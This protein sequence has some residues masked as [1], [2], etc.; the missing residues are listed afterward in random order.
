MTRATSLFIRPFAV[1]AVAALLLLYVLSLTA[2][3]AR[4][5]APAPADAP[6]AA[7][8]VEVGVIDPD[9]LLSGSD[10]LLLRTET[11]RLALPPQVTHVE[12]AVFGTNKENFNDTMLDYARADRPDLVSGDSWA[13]GRLIVAV[14][15]DPHRNG[16]YCGDD[17]CVALDIFE[18]PHLDGSLEAMKDPLRRGN[19]GA[20]LLAG[21]VAAADP[22]VVASGSG[23][24][25]GGGLWVLG[26]AGLVLAGGGAFVVVRNRRKTVATAR[27]QFDLVSREYGRVAGE[28][29]G[30]DVRANSLSSVLADDDLRAQWADVRDRFLELD[31]VMGRLGD[32]RYDSTDAEFR[33]AAKDIGTA[34]G[35]VEQMDRAETNID[36]MFRMEQGDVDV[37][38]RHLGELHRDMGAAALGTS[39]QRLA[40]Q[41]R[42]LVGQVDDLARDPA[43]PDFMDRYARIVRDYRLVVD[44]IRA[45]DLSDVKAAK[46]AGNRHAPRIYD[47]DWQV[48][49]GYHG[50]VPYYVA[51]TWHAQ[52]VA[53][54]SSSTDTGYSDSSFSGGGGSSSW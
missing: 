28:L 38:R 24:G 7:A 20:G 33:K 30:I 36:T 37:R 32:L 8:A 21:A 17:V 39:D 19:I 2:G 51:S 25:D 48:G 4:A 3:P 9:D 47:N 23:D 27:E 15:M 41:A 12:Y 29:T 40:D 50:F 49:S 26:V 43:V 11:S 52:D 42:T 1:A 13:P 54:A 31:T 16:I 22:S 44:A 45:R 46:G 6:P 34:H 18:G 10:E 14:G 5:Q 35:T 53:A